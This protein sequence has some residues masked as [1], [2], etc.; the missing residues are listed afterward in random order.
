[1]L[2]AGGGIART[3][4]REEHDI[5]RTSV[6]RF[7]EAEILPDYDQWE[8][9]G[10]VPQ[11]AWLKAGAAGLLCTTAP[12]AYGGS[13]TDRL[14][15]AILDEELA[16]LGLRSVFFGLH[17]EIVAP[18]I[19]NYG[20][21]D[22]KRR[23]LPRMVSG[24][25]I[26]AIAMTEPSC[27]SDLKAIRTRAVRKGD[28]YVVSGQKTFISNGQTADTIVVAVKTSPDAGAKGV[29][30]LVIEGSSPGLSRRRL[31]KL[32]MHAQ[33][34]SELFFDDV[35]VPAE[36]LLGI[37]GQGFGMMMSELAWERM[38]I[39]VK[40]IAISEAALE[41]TL[42]YTKMREAFGRKIFDFQNTRFRLAELAT[43]T[44][45][46]RVFVDRCLVLANERRLDATTAAMVKC[47][48]S[49]MTQRLLDQCLQLHG[50]CGYMWEYPI[51]RA[52]ADFRHQPI[53]GGSNE[54]MKDLIART[55]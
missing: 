46:G 27:G 28:H 48:T 29:S 17:S 23:F 34:T 45:I 3:I 35:L 26:G 2:R 25:S 7:L 4:F 55:L 40:S 53:A 36:N 44:Q 49:E 21:E 24:E 9:E 13:G 18:Y 52:F 50:G 20:T 54:I 47:W 51:A 39:G 19:I 42:D 11:S 14:F 1:M 32:G 6:R 31:R 8:D 16:Y 5:F 12:E 41:W 15:A 10:Q 43:E 22:Q 33:D 30:L 37:E 38:Q